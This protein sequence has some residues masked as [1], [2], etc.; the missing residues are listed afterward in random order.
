V[1]GNLGGGEFSEMNLRTGKFADSIEIAQDISFRDT[2]AQ[3]YLVQGYD[4]RQFGDT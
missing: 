3:G 1:E 2:T 4:I